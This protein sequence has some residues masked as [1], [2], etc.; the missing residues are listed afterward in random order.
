VADALLALDLEH[1]TP[2]TALDK[3]FE[4]KEMLSKGASGKPT[5]KS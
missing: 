1:L 3:L 5:K 4:I 2:R